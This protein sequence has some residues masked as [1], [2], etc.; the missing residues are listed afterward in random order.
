MP[1][2]GSGLRVPAARLGT[3]LGVPI[4]VSASWLIFALLVTVVY[5]RIILSI[6]PVFVQALAFALGMA[7]MWGIS[8][9]LHEL[10]H[11]AAGRIMGSRVYR[12]EIGFL[13]GATETSTSDERPGEE[14]WVSIAGPAVSMVLAAPGLIS[15]SVGSTLSFGATGAWGLLIG[16]FTLSN[17][18][19]AVFNMLPG[20]PLDGGRVLVALLW[21]LRGNQFAA[22]RLASTVG[23]VIA[24]LLLGLIVVRTITA[25]TSGRQLLLLAAIAIVAIM[26]WN[27]AVQSRRAAVREQRLS[28]RPIEPYIAAAETVPRAT[29]AAVATQFACGPE[30]VVVD[31]RFMP[32]GI[33]NRRELLANP[34]AMVDQLMTPVN[35]DLLLPE[36]AS[37][38]DIL[39]R[40]DHTGES[41]FIV[42][43]RGRAVIGTISVQAIAQELS[44][45][46]RRAALAM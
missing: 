11:V 17:L 21:K 37:V 30:L 16:T 28:T 38:Y 8:V 22:S 15:A 14:F 19:V 18:V 9:L 23:Q 39:A 13:G 6:G 32:L 1:I 33:V 7:L 25:T 40:Y 4:F 5:T 31:D 3:F 41:R 45:P 35:D 12:V 27:M 20:L 10:G 43:G 2:P 24:V 44:T 34:V 46:K 36:R 29:P 26:L 42:I